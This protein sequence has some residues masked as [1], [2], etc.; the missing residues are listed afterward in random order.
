M[1]SHVLNEQ[2]TGNEYLKQL[3]RI[4]NEAC[5]RKDHSNISMFI[6]FECYWVKRKDVVHFR[7]SYI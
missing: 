6:K 7:K 3:N 1:I 5:H 2:G 4:E